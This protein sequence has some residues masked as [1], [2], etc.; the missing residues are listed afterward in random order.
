MPVGLPAMAASP[1][2]TSGNGHTGFRRELATSSS[3]PMEA[4]RCTG[5]VDEGS[6]MLIRGSEFQDIAEN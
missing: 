4:M 5:E 3:K 6:S 2:V 1:F